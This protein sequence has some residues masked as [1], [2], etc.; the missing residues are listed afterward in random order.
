MSEQA[1]MLLNDDGSASVATAL[2]TSHHGF[3]RDLALFARALATA[4]NPEPGQA[5]A[6]REEWA[7]FH[8]K[9]HGHH[10]AEDHGLFPAILQQAPALAPVLEK[11]KAEH[12]LIDPL[13]AEGDAAFSDQAAPGAAAALVGKLSGLLDAHLATEE[14]NAVPF[15]RNMKGFPPPASDAEVDMFVDGFAWSLHGV[16]P[17]VA[18]ALQAMLPPIVL[19]RL[20]GARAAFVQRSEKVWGTAATGASRRSI[21]DWLP[22]GSA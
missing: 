8:H 5:A 19:A 16:A 6:L 10:E 3:R 22:G 18:A 7:S 21:P 20:P 9:L 15:L 17:E 11:L 12:R 4:R 2:L 1:P 14:A 13:L